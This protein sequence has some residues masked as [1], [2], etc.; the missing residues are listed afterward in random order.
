[1]SP[2]GRGQRA[3]FCSDPGLE[4]A[5]RRARAG[6]K[7][8]KTSRKLRERGPPPHRGGR[9][10]GPGADPGKIQKQNG[11]P[12]E[13]RKP[14]GSEDPPGLQEKTRSWVAQ[15]MIARG[16]QQ[17]GDGHMTKRCG[18]FETLFRGGLKSRSGNLGRRARERRKQTEVGRTIA[19]VVKRPWCPRGRSFSPRGCL[20]SARAPRPRGTA[21]R[22]ARPAMN[23]C[24]GRRNPKAGVRSPLEDRAT[25]A[26]RG[27][28]SIPTDFPAGARRR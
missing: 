9:C 26:L 16:R 15:W 10:R 28:V 8:R 1:M 24:P 4:L 21:K 12:G 18:P 20:P 6:R 11:S 7:D 14:V 22:P 19:N 17:A 3:F 23:D 2:Q 13:A 25:R 27:G 5:P